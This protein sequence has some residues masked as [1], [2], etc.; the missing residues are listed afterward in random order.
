MAFGVAGGLG[1]GLPL[2]IEQGD[3]N[4][5]T[6]RAVLQ[7]LGKDIQLVMVTMHRQAD[8]AQG[9]QRGG[10]A[11]AVVPGLIHNGD[12]DARLLQRFDLGQRQ[13]QLLAGI[14]RGVKIETPGIDQIRHLQQ[15]IGLPVS[16]G[17]AVFPL[18]DKGCQRLGLHAVE[19][20]VDVIDVE[21]HHR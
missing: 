15:R 8:I 5:L 6:R 14:A 21:R 18:A 16:Q 13:E 11:V 10:I 2:L 4:A 9:K 3:L 17:V 20:N 19:V 12:I 7:A 1:Q